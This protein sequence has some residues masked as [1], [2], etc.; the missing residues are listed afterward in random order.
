MIR[1]EAEKRVES[2]RKTIN[3]YR[4]KYHVLDESEISEDALDTLKH[5]LQELEREFPELI[6]PDS[7]TQRVGGEALEKFEK[8]EHKTP[9]LSM[10]DVFSFDE[11]K[12]WKNRIEKIFDDE[13]NSFYLMPKIDGLAVTLWYE[14]GILVKAITRGNGKIGEDVTQNV[15][16]IQSIPLKLNEY[17]KYSKHNGI[18]EIRG[19]IYISKE[20]FEKLNEKQKKEN[21][22]TF[23]NPRNLAAGSIRQL[24]PKIAGSRKLKF[25][26]W[27][28]SDLG[29]KT[30]LESADLLKRFGFRVVPGKRVDLENSEDFFEE[31]EKKRKDLEYWIDG[32]VLRVDNHN[33]FNNLGVVGKA[34]RGL[35]A[36]KFP[37][38]EATTILREVNWN[39]GRTGKL[40][41]VATVDPVFIAGTTV[42]HA[43]LHNADEIERLDLRI[44]DTVILVKAG[45]IIPKILKVLTQ[46]RDGS[47]EKIVIP[48]DCPICNDRLV[49]NGENIDLICSNDG[50]FSTEVQKIAYAVK[51]FSIDG[52]G[53]KTIERLFKNGLISSA[54]DIFHL[55][56]DEIK[57]L[58]G[59][60][61]VSANKLIVEIAKHKVIDFDKFI[62]AL[63]IPQVGKETAVALAYRYEK[64]EDL[65]MA[66]LDELKSVKD[67]GEVVA[68]EIY[69]FFNN[70][71]TQKL[72]KDYEEAGIV[73]KSKKK[74]ANHLL[75]LTFVVTGSLENFTRDEAQEAI[76]QAG[77][78]VSNS[79]SKKTSFVV[80]GAAAGSKARKAEELGISI[81]DENEFIKKLNDK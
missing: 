62:V 63:G 23:A 50:C 34:P 72:L 11:V 61:E 7:P 18:I 41:P 22:K 3:E 73:I 39:I 77:G 65:A 55:K 56:A 53:E 48:E 9:M 37:P 74:V 28:I 71:R 10:E 54:P 30:Q 78:E 5:E 2:L 58:E 25:I 46:M 44:G 59:F 6:T 1:S 31:I 36:W 12:A 42:T 81:L 26:A 49:K 24:D 19:E 21:A 43:S 75:G 8:V 47:E 35:I 70:E 64:I 13:I 29:Q 16:T 60:A 33:I 66:N 14:K 51:V 17:E 15:K 76:R 69:N 32:T 45:D 20:D 67:I 80:V 27:W 79:V 68:K 4:Y 40:T 52:L 38:E 57:N